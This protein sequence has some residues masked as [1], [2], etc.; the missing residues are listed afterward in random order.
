MTKKLVPALLTFLLVVSSLSFAQTI[1]QLAHPAPDG[2]ILPFQM[3]DG[4]II[5]QGYNENDW[6]KLTPDINGSYVNGTWTQ[7]A[8]LPTGYVPD[9]FA[10]AV[11]ADG[12]LLIEG[13]EYNEGRFAFTSLGAIYDP[14]ANTWTPMPAPP[15]WGFIG[16]SPSSVMPDSKFMMGQKFTEAMAWLD[17]DTL[18]WTTLGSSGKSD[19]FA[20]EGWTLMP[21]G[22]VLTVDVLN[23]PNSERY[24]TGTSR[25]G[26]PTAAPSPTC[27]VRR[28]SAASP[29]ATTS[30]IT[31]RAKSV[32]PFC[33][34][35]APYIATGATHTGASAGHTATY[36][37]GRTPRIR[38]PGPRDPTSP[39]VTMPATI[40][41]YC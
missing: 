21:D 30:F 10:S 31:R 6:W 27:R 28:K 7:V 16:D 23:N 40:L 11:L 2:G 18:T 34:P 13:G 20:E 8:G 32:L 37:P 36:K 19:W 24:I 17:P 4:T 41:P 15:G 33:A 1:T 29:M 39:T 9:A 35:T 3:T 22:T 26:F 38:A 12:R 25:C 14:V 5:V